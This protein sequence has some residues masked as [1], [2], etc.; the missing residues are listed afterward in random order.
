MTES[1]IA[2]E[3]GNAGFLAFLAGGGSYAQWS[4]FW[5]NLKEGYDLFEQTGEPPTAFACGD[6]Y[7]FGEA[8]DSCKRVAG[9]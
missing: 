2:R 1:A 5:R 9:W 7:A 6:H 8:G 3:T 4:G